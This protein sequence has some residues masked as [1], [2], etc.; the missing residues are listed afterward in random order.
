[1]ISDELY[2]RLQARAVPF[3]DTIESVIAKMCDQ[4]DG[5]KVDVTPNIQ[6]T[7]KSAH[8]L[9]YEH[10]A[11][12]WTRRAKANLFRQHAGSLLDSCKAASGGLRR[13]IAMLRE[14]LDAIEQREAAKFGDIAAKFGD[15]QPTNSEAAFVDSPEAEA[16]VAVA[17]TAAIKEIEAKYGDLIAKPQAAPKLFR[18]NRRIYLPVGAELIGEYLGKKVKA[19]VQE[20][21]IEF[22]G[23]FFDN[24]S[25]AAVAAKKSLGASEKAAQSNGWTFWQIELHPG[26][27]F[28]QP[29]E[30]LRER[31]QKELNDLLSGDES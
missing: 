24:P 19:M 5:M 15:V 8:L 17:Y 10:T 3:E 16:A 2:A 22:Q 23:E 26:L 21:G 25:A 11:S 6:L 4:L 30:V 12:V 7:S 14:I 13:E 27:G 9:G 1:M 18:T 20:E 29:L 31:Q 28:Y